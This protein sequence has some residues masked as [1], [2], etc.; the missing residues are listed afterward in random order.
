MTRFFLAGLLCLVIAGCSAV[1]F[2]GA[3]QAP[4]AIA[5]PRDIP[6]RFGKTVPENFQLVSSIVFEFNLLSVSG[7]GYVDIDTVSGRYKVLCINQLGVKL[8]EFQGDR[9]RVLGRYAI[10]PLARQGNIVDAV[11]EDIRRVYLDLVPSADARIARKKNS[12]IFRQRHGEGALDYEFAGRVPKLIRKTYREDHRAA[13]SVFY[14][15]YL[16]KNDKLYP[17]GIVFRNYRYGY[18]LIVKHK[19]I[20]G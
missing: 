17:M 14:S 20:R 18:S 8:F 6:E 9:N 7:I 3:E 13:W 1:P 16:Q 4:V 11:A 19:E 10:E 2:H 12:V 15:E 5:D